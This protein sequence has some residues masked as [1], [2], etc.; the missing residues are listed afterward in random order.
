MTRGL[1]AGWAWVGRHLMHIAG[2]QVRPRAV[3]VEHQRDTPDLTPVVER[4]IT[5]RLPVVWV[6]RTSN[7]N[8]GSMPSLEYRILLI[9][10]AVPG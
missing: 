1:G 6:L 4:T 5:S 8:D 2:L 10:R 3:G 7:R 9:R